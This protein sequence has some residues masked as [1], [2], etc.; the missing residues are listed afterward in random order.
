MK[1]AHELRP[2]QTYYLLYLNSQGSI[3][4]GDKIEI[5]AGKGRLAHVLVR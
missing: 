1:Q 2:G 3:K 4:R 5:G